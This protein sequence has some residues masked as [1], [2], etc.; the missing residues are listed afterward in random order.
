M[1]TR[2]T[3]AVATALAA[4]L[5]ALA[6]LA[7]AG[8]VPAQD[9]RI[10]CVVFVCILLWATGAIPGYLV[11][12]LFF[13]LAVTLTNVPVPEIFS[14][15]AS[16]AFWLVQRPVPFCSAVSRIMSTSGSPVSGSTSMPPI[17]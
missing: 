2:S 15:F 3:A 16:S 14:G 1:P 6:A 5:A 13:L 7:A 9:A 10:L 12:L 8:M 17:T 11:S 4:G